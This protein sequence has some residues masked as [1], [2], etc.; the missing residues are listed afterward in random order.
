MEV[1][2]LDT[3]KCLHPQL[4]TITTHLYLATLPSLPEAAGPGMGHRRAEDSETWG[5]ILTQQLSN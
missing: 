3:A 2:F 1:T 5:Q 4:P